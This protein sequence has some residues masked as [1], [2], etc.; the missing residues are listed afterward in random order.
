M[1]KLTAAVATA[2]AAT[3]LSACGGSPGDLMSINVTGGP[4]NVKQDI[5]IRA[6]G[7][8]TC[9]GG[10]SKDIGSE[11]LIEAREIEREVGDIAKRGAVYEARQ[12]TDL[13]LR[14]YI[15]RRDDGEVR[16]TETAR[17]L[18]E[19]LARAQL[20]ALQLGRDLC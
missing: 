2:A 17:G 6:D 20:L 18:P 4:G 11:K 15:L 3:A 10:S 7:Q 1:R 5:V 14:D 19:I 16:W 8:A 13:K 12:K 9:N